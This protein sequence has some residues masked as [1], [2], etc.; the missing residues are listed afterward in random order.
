MKVDCYLRN[1]TLHVF[2]GSKIERNAGPTPVIDLQLASNE[3]LGVRISSDIRLLT[4]RAHRLAQDGARV[5]LATHSIL[6]RCRSVE[7]AYR[8]DDL[9]LLVPNRIGIEGNWWLHRRHRQELK[10][11][12]RHH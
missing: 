3:R 12:I 8:L 1:T 9:S 11:V 6:K 5:V 4:I 10:Y 7:W 2:A